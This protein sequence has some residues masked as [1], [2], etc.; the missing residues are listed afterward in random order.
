MT[1]Q[2]QVL[3]LFLAG[4][5]TGCG[6]IAAQPTPDGGTAVVIGG[7]DGGGGIT[8]NL[9][10]VN[11]ASLPRADAGWLLIEASSARIEVDPSATDAITAVGACSD[12]V[13]YCATR[14]NSLDTCVSSARSCLTSIPWHEPACCPA[15]CKNGYVAARATL[16]PIPAFEK[17]FFEDL[18]CFPGLR[19]A[20][21]GT[22]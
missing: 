4:A 9:P 13:T 2:T 14:G 11:V 12:L 1:R 6:L 22:P 10:V 20:L 18:D 17:A 15:A 19:A 3:W 8:V 21:E 5:A 16:A 7:T